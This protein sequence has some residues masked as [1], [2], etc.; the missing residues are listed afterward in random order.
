MISELNGN[1]ANLVRLA[2]G[3]LYIPG[4]F[5]IVD[6]LSAVSET[7]LLIDN[8]DNTLFRHSPEQ[9][10]R[11][12]HHVGPAVAVALVG[13]HLSRPQARRVTEVTAA[14]FTRGL[15]LTEQSEEHR[16][17]GLRVLDLLA[18]GRLNVRVHTRG[19]LT[20]RFG[21][22]G[23][24]GSHPESAWVGTR[25]PL[26]AAE[27]DP[28][29]VATTVTEPTAR[30]E[31]SDH[32][33]RLW[34]EAADATTLL[35]DAIRRSWV[36]ALVSPHD[37]YLKTL[38]TL[39]RDRLEFDP[40]ELPGD[41]DITDQLADFQRAAFRQAVRV[42]Q[43]FG[44]VFVADVVGLG[45]SFVGAA[46]VRYFERT[47]HVRPLIV[48]PAP[49]V[50]MWQA[51]SETHRLN[52]HVVSSGILRSTGGRNPLL[53]EV[54]YRDRDF[55]LID[56]SHSFRNPGSQR[57]QV[58]A[59]FMA[60]GRKRACLLT[61]TPRNRSAWDVCH[62]IRLFHPDDRTTLPIDPPHLR[63]Y[64]RLIERRER[65]LPSLLGHLLV[66]RT[67]S[68][69]LR[70]Y[71]RDAE[72]GQPV[73][74]DRFEPYRDGARRAY[75][76]VGGR[77]QFFPR[78]ELRTAEYS[79]EATYRGLYDR[80]RLYLTP[81]PVGDSGPHPDRLLFA[82]YR[83]GDYLTAL[84]RSRPEYAALRTTAGL[85]G[86]VRVMLFKRFESSVEA[87]RTTVRRMADAHRG[88]LASLAV[89]VVPGAR[90]S[91]LDTSADEDEET[92][93]NDG[94]PT[95]DF[96]SA[97][98]AADL[99]HDLE[100]L[101]RILGMIELITPDEDQKLQT[102]IRLLGEPPLA[103]AKRLI[104]T[105]FADTARYLHAH[106]AGFGE[107]GCQVAVLTSETPSKMAA[108]GRFA[109]RSN[110][111]TAKFVATD[112]IGTL[113][114][115]DVLS[116]GLNLQDAAAVVNYDLH[117][118][119]V[120]LI[121]RFGRVDRIGS[122][123]DRIHA[124]NFLPEVGLERNLGL[125]EVL[126][127][128]IRDIHETIGEDSSILE[129]GEELNEAAMYAMYA[130]GDGS[131]D[132][133]EAEPDDRSVHLAE[134]EEL[135][136]HLRESNPSEYA[137]IASLPDGVRSTRRGSRAGV[138]AFFQAGN[139]REL[140]LLD[141]RGAIVSDDLPKLLG[142]LRCPPNATHAGPYP[143][144]LAGV[145]V[146][147]ARVFDQRAAE[148][149]T[150]LRHAAP[151]TGG[152]RYALRE[153]R[154]A[155]AEADGDDE[156]GRLERLEGVFRLPVPPAASRELNRARRD[157]LAGA[158]MIRHLVTILH[159][160][161]LADRRPQENEATYDLAGI[162]CSLGYIPGSSS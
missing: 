102:L 113:I 46:V 79:I 154:V 80:L 137:R 10:V 5:A 32:F 60:R 14:G 99:G 67:R 147:A 30:T 133:L 68:H 136:R 56:E 73:D 151:L 146:R 134:A 106:L 52:A 39:V 85:H 130:G 127:R 58:L 29:G 43:E 140:V 120:R 70:F 88:V 4:L 40:A 15:E 116:E 97:R 34:T 92:E 2:A 107:P 66:R 55:V 18:T 119:P 31:L 23:L 17:G 53:D 16:L 128:R 22:S 72:T 123:H 94:Y 12:A 91:G 82:R 63:D 24:P 65:D 122:E 138:F 95:E 54:R 117:W 44:G 38:F 3:Y 86:M 13:E 37:I 27:L 129:A 131:F 28:S 155:I 78:R 109:P 144:N 81:P 26:I 69:V 9:L 110:P 36:A 149:R 118:N 62:Q 100:L 111:D 148:R 160:Y 108:V 121:Q 126:R 48:C 75:I 161:G 114:S 49:L 153:L 150:E 101:N 42:I 115:T 64:F 87:F 124:V 162:V 139:Y 11:D 8:T 152:Q 90:E 125:R 19:R 41:E 159:A 142:W 141:E 7:R 105:Q 50:E 112:E 35:A 61:A 57:Y 45:K 6:R 74:P 132:T 76:E 103:G 20:A 47:E 1:S 84:A 21:C 145:L 135:L 156:R 71:G 59:E 158:A 98:L 157:G 33:D 104:F 25:N 143:P 93:P 96:D 51:Y 89:G 77:C 83:I